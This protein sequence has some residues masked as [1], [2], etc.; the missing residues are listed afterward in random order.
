MALVEVSDRGPGIPESELTS[1]FRPFYRVDMARSAQTGGVGVGLAIAERAV[2]LHN[3]R[4]SASNRSGGGT[5]IR[6]WLPLAA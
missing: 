3:G 5:T 4:I 1:I 6:I 2:K